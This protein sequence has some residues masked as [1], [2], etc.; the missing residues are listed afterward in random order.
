MA[1]EH[2]LTFA[3]P[4]KKTQ[5]NRKVKIARRGK[6]QFCQPEQYVHQDS[7]KFGIDIQ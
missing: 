7:L 1:K 5:F 4:K 3:Y 2:S 6:S